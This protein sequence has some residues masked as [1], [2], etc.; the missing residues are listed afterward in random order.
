MPHSFIAALG[1]AAFIA[2]LVLVI[3]STWVYIVGA[4]TGGTFHLGWK[5]Y[6]TIDRGFTMQYPDGFLVDTE[7]TYDGLGRSK[8]IR[9]VAFKIPAR[10]AEGT[11][12][13]AYD[14]RF[15]VEELPAAAECAATAFLHA[16]KAKQA[17]TEHGTE[18]AFAAQRDA[19]GADLY[20]E[21]VYAI[22]GSSPCVAVRYSVHSKLP[23]TYGA[24]TKD[25]DRT[26]LLSTFDVMRWSLSLKQH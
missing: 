17:I 2:L 8:E 4:E 7:Y 23:G 21:H 11:N 15:S 1:F 5:T 24:D 16:P 3:F 22:K 6:A 14:T 18:Y 26:A 20:E 12:L 19:H 10:M 25:F 9:G 13:D